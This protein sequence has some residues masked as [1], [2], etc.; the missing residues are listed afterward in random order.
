MK[1][2]I[3]NGWALLVLAIPG[4]LSACN[5]SSMSTLKNRCNLL[6]NFEL[7]RSKECL[8]LKNLQYKGLSTVL[9]VDNRLLLDNIKP[10]GENDSVFD[11]MQMSV[12]SKSTI[13]KP[14][15]S[16]YIATTNSWNGLNHILTYFEPTQNRK[17]ESCFV[18]QIQLPKEVAHLLISG[19]KV[20]KYVCDVLK[21][22][23]FNSSCKRSLKG[24][25]KF[26]DFVFYYDQESFYKE[27]EIL[28]HG[29][30]K[31]NWVTSIDQYT[32]RNGE[33]CTTTLVKK[34]HF[35][36]IPLR[37]ELTYHEFLNQYDI[38]ISNLTPDGLSQ[39][40]VDHLPSVPE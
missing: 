35:S 21:T 18:Y 31:S 10:W 14:K 24:Q 11:H 16:N 13:D 5:Q 23:S 22:K 28:Y 20:F 33:W 38:R 12:G 34:D 40:R 32:Y 15:D 19:K 39:E 26:Q 30:I 4:L 3:M 9:R 1:T 2:Y 8:I 27:Q 36:I 25:D 37:N 6:P 17:K 29:P 7:C